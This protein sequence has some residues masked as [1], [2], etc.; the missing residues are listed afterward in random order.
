MEEGVHAVCHLQR[1]GRTHGVFLVQRRFGIDA[2]VILRAPGDGPYLRFGCKTI[3]RELIEDGDGKP[4]AVLR[5]ELITESK[6]VIVEPEA[7]IHT[8]LLRRKS[9]LHLVMLIPDEALL[10]P[11]GL[12]CRVGTIV[13]AGLHRPTEVAQR[14]STGEEHKAHRRRQEDVLALVGNRVSRLPL[15]QCKRQGHPPVR[16]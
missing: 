2:L 3:R 13:R 1:D 4:V 7:D 8:Q 15:T 10:S 6:T 12:P 11:D 14:V 5:R 16:G 9:H